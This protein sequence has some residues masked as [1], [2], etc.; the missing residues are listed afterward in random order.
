MLPSARS[1]R[2]VE[3]FP[4]NLQFHRMEQCRRAGEI[5]TPKLHFHGN[6]AA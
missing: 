3:S 4:A 1:K 2:F 6:L 5:N